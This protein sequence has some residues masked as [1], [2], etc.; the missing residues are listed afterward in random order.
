V[1]GPLIERVDKLD[2][3]RRQLRTVVRLF[4]QDADVVDELDRIGARGCG[5]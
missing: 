2:A 3:A 5:L 4:F 1:A